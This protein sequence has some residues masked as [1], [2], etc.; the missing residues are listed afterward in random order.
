MAHDRY[1]IGIDVGG[2]FTDIV[3]CDQADGSLT[4]HKAPTTPHDIASGIQAALGKSGAP[5]DQIAEIAHGTTVAT[6]ALLER[7]G[8]RTGLLT[9]AG[10]RDLLE[11]RDGGRRTL[12]G[13][14]PAFEPVI[15][16][17]WRWEATERL[18][19]SG[20]VLQALA[21][22][23]IAGLV[24]ALTAQGIEALAISF[25]HAD[26]NDTHERRAREI[27]R[28]HWPAGS[29]VLGNEVGPFP[30]ERLRTA[31]AALAAYLTPLMHRYVAALERVLSTAGMSPVFRFIE[32]AGASLTPEEVRRSPLQTVLSGPAGG[33]VA[34][35]AL[36]QLLRLSSAVTADMGGTS[37]DVALLQEGQPHLRADRTLEFGLQIAVPC[38]DI[39]TVGIGGGSLAWLDESVAGGLQ[40]GPQSA[41]AHPGPACFGK[42]GR[43]PTVTDASLLLD[44]LVG[45]RTDLGLPP[46]DPAPAEQ[47][48]LAEV[49]SGFGMEPRDAA[50]MVIEVA[51]ARMAA[52]LRTQLTARGTSPGKATL[53]AFGGAGPVHAAP[54]AQRLGL[55]RVVIPYLASGFSALGCLLCPPAKVALLAVNE[56]LSA[57]SPSR[58]REL[59]A[60]AF[61]LETSGHLRLALVTRRGE[62]PHEDL[63][64]VRD[65]DEP[66][67]ARLRRYQTFAQH[68][69]R[70]PAG[71]G[72]HS[73]GAP[74]R[75]AGARNHR[76][77]VRPLPR[78]HLP[79]SP[80]APVCGVRRGAAEPSRN[81]PG[82]G[83]VARHRSPG[84]RAGP[85]RPAGGQRLRPAGD[86]IP[87]RS[88]GK[89][90][91]GDHGMTATPLSPL[92]PGSGVALRLHLE[93]AATAMDATLRQAAGSASIGRH[94]S[95]AAGFYLPTGALLLGGRESHPLLAESAAE[96]L[97]NLVG[98][99]QSADRPIASGELYL[100]NDPDCEAAGVEDLV[101]ATPIVRDGRLVAFVALTASHP[102]LGRAT[103][104]PVDR[105]RRE[106]LVLPWLR[107]GHLGRVKAETVSLLAANADDPAE[108]RDDFAAQL[109][110]LGLGRSALEDALDRFGADGLAGLADVA[111]EG[112]RRALQ[113][114]LSKLESDEIVGRAAP[115]TAR[116]R[117]DGSPV[118]VLVEGSDPGWGLTPALARAAV[119][120]AIREA[121]ATESPTLAVLGGLAEA[122]SIQTPPGAAPA[123]R[124]SGEARFGGAQAVADAIRAAFAGTLSHLTHAPDAACLL[125]DLR[126]ERNDGS[127]YQTRLG[128][129]GGLG[130]SVFGDGLTHGTS[131][132]S[133]HRTH[134]VEE[135]ERGLPV[136]I[137]RFEI[138]ADSAGPGQYHGGAG[139]RLELQ[140]LEGQAEADLLL[141]G[142]ALGMQGGMRGTDAR[143]LHVTVRHGTRECPDRA[144]SPSAWRRGIASSWKA[145]A[146]AAGASPSSAPSC[147]WRRISSEA[148]SPPISRA[149]ATAW[150]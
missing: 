97:A 73:G 144:G 128:L 92:P 2:T 9:T 83:G 24:S 98:R 102:G 35:A 56:R 66:E 63:L 58:L 100:T 84:D 95:T 145:P 124:P 130:A 7:K 91:P 82:T 30:D 143:V 69:L 17:H 122:L 141:P 75:R 87:R 68:A 149:I 88:L 29:L 20:N 131:T 78:G 80:G 123:R 101:L 136:R 148:S 126:G 4:L 47:A 99:H 15:P 37:F 112:A 62:N 49:C 72:D 3:V 114:M 19:A 76:G 21:E 110:A 60:A 46:L 52:F 113:Q 150:S 108:F 96:A 5:A 14:Q 39:Q 107:A 26:Q 104:A 89:P 105:L 118:S 50:R 31:T 12:R 74:A 90:D 137:L 142:R 70:R 67:E 36:S 27:L 8:A 53:I 11:L 115:F 146:G 71:G 28:R 138:L 132:F 65:P 120:A 109:H 86:S 32:S 54:V 1:H 61:P 45:D 42:G 25:I 77:R 43:K 94:G 139:V 119:R 117:R 134:G 116:I 23:E 51:E 6:N 93:E 129:P 125:A 121:A 106:G 18:D 140:L 55:K 10:F 127:R 13:W 34:G 147:G 59:S 41:G 48:M 64:V 44:R 79:P 85:R 16:R 135:I 33:A 22:D 103:L 133:P 81:T 111:A 40:V 57:L 38:V